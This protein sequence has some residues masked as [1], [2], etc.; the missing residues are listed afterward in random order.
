MTMNLSHETKLIFR[1]FVFEFLH[2]RR[3]AVLHV[4]TGKTSA[5][6]AIM[7]GL[8]TPERVS[9]VIFFVLL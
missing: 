6:E 4:G 5:E 8:L 3:Y 9:Y 7:N 2:C 1:F